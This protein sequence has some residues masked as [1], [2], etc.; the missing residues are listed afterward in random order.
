MR[1]RTFVAALVVVS[2]AFAAGCGGQSGENSRGDG[3]GL[4]WCEDTAGERLMI[5]DTGAP[6]AC[7]SLTEDEAACVEARDAG[8]RD[9][10]V[11]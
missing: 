6:P 10:D 7:G 1:M 3:G 8:M 2:L 5:R 9:A 4:C 11:R